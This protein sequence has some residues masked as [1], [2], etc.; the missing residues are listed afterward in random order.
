MFQVMTFTDMGDED[1]A[2]A[3]T[4]E[5]V[6]V[7]RAR[8]RRNGNPRLR[9]LSTILPRAVRPVDVLL[10]AVFTSQSRARVMIKE[11]L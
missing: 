2:M 6:D 5:N 3:A 7:T 4:E 1:A 8:V 11:R 9:C 10:Q